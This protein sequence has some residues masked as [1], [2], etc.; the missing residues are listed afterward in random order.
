VRTTLKGEPARTADGSLLTSNRRV[1]LGPHSAF[2][3]CLVSAIVP[4]ALYQLGRR[5][6]RLRARSAYCHPAACSRAVSQTQLEAKQK[7]L[8]AKEAAK[9]RAAEEE[10][11]RAEAELRVHA[12]RQQQ[13][14]REAQELARKVRGYQSCESP[15]AAWISSTHYSC[16]WLRLAVKVKEREK[17]AAEQ[18][19]EEAA[20]AQAAAAARARTEAAAAAKAAAEAEARLRRA[21][22][23]AAAAAAREAERARRAAEEAAKRARRAA[24]CRQAILT[25]HFALWRKV[26]QH[27]TPIWIISGRFSPT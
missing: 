20:V 24:K 7:A 14:L 2:I 11:A 19:A 22:E 18:Q 13:L 4:I 3:S 1:S 25:L 6:Y 21:R 10:A 15:C 8:E 23:E 27:S 26:P 12:E 16:D 5:C 9:V 17:M